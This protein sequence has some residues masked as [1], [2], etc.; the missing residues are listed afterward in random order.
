MHDIAGAVDAL[1][2]LS[3]P[4]PAIEA[5]KAT[6]TAGRVLAHRARL[7]NV[8]EDAEGPED[9]RPEP[10]RIKRILAHPLPAGGDGNG[11]MVSSRSA[12]TLLRK[13]CHKP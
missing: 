13:T 1:P 9:F 5:G 2:D 6:G 10:R 8:G 12:G 3:S 4:P 7:T 11:R